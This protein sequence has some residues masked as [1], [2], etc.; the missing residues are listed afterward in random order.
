M[1]NGWKNEWIWVSVESE[2]ISQPAKKKD[3]RGRE[4]FTSEAHACI[5]AASSQLPG[6]SVPFPHGRTTQRNSLG[7]YFPWERS[8]GIEWVLDFDG[9]KETQRR[10]WRLMSIYYIL[11][12][13]CNYSNS[14]RRRSSWLTPLP[15]FFFCFSDCFLSYAIIDCASRIIWRQSR[16]R[17]NLT[18]EIKKYITKQ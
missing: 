4:C 16:R 18:A 12:F 5:V 14:K 11:Y 15:K 17:C 3:G 13:S 6:Q 9:R 7:I 2:W 8:I 10:R 1:P